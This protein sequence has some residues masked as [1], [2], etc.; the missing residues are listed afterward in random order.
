MNLV[1]AC[2]LL[3]I[4]PKDID[5]PIL[6]KKYKSKCLRFHPDKK[7][8]KE[9]FIELKEAYDFIINQ[10]KP[11]SFLDDMDETFL[12]QYLY[13]IYKSDIELFKHPLFIRHFID[14]VQEHLNHYKHY[15]LHPKIEQLLR[16]DVYYLE[17][18]KL[19]IPLWHEEIT[20]DKKIR[21][22]LDPV[23]PANIELDDNNNILVLYEVKD[24]IVWG[25]ISISIT[26]QEKKEKRIIGKGI[27]RI[28]TSLYDA[29]E[30][31]DI[32]LLS[33]SYQTSL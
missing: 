6:K 31:S 15:I 13:S 21:I 10:P 30:L 24:K 9:K 8:D 7:G 4:S 5:G 27:P 14:P 33:Q 17:E 3:D 2:H 12:R 26:E 20:F 1:R 29:S 16:K 19:Y 22:T 18:E 11:S 23:L 28:Q 32:I 25:S